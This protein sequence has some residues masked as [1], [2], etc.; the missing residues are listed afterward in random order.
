MKNNIYKSLVK[1]NSKVAKVQTQSV[2][3]PLVVNVPIQKV[4]VPVEKKSF[5]KAYPDVQKVTVLNQPKPVAVQK[6]EVTNPVKS[7]K[8]EFPKVQ[9]VE[10]TNL[11]KQELTKF[12]D[13][14]DVRVLNQIEFPVGKGDD[15]KYSDPEQFIPVRL[16][17]GKKFYE[18]QSDAYVAA[19]KT[20]FPYVDIN[21]K[22]KPV[23]LTTDGRLPV[24]T[25]IDIGDIEIGAVEI[26]NSTD[27]TRATVG[28]NG[29]Y[30]DV[31][32]SVLPTGAATS[33]KQLADNHQ[34]TVSNI[35]ST[36]V[37]SGFALETGGNLATIAGA[38]GSSKMNVNISSGS[39]ANT[40]FAVTNTGTF[41]TQETPATTIY[42]GKKVVTT[43]G[44]RVA[45][46]SSQAVKS[47]TIK[48]LV[49]N[50]GIIYVGD[51]AVAAANGY[52]LSAGDTISLDIANLATINL[53]SSVSGEGVTF[54]AIG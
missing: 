10:V 36:P 48:A 53:D 20:V 52:A 42:N 27:D 43:A 16:T 13:S 18:A 41:A 9:K 30:V 31:R 15:P 25:T 33:A 3:I 26:K 50:T 39:I 24:D 5:A 38:V 34:V 37:I 21:G 40:T 6:V 1:R 45:L 47:V 28:A 17:N 32:A 51:G 29:L 7:E 22:A 46:T 49:A 35:A 19:A 23:Q 12:P 2:N 11:P 14:Q 4:E 8:I 44:T 54:V